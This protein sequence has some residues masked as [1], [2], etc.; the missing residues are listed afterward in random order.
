MNRVLLLTAG[1]CFALFAN[2]QTDTTTK[3]DGWYPGGDTLRVGNILIIRNGPQERATDPYVR[4]R[5]R[6]HD[7]NSYRPPN[8]TTSWGI[9]D[10]G[11]TNYN[12]KTVYT[13][14]SAQQFA[15]GASKDWFKLND[16]KSVDVN[17]WIAVQRLNLIKHVVNLKYGLGIELNNYRYEDNIRFLT[18]PTKVIMDTI[19]YTKNKLAEDF[20][21][22]P[23]MLNF[24]FT[25]HRRH[26][27]G[28]SAGASFG[29]RY[30]SREKF[31]SHEDGKQFTYNDF[32]LYSW[33]I[34]YIGEVQ[35]G[36]WISL[37]GSYATK[38]IFNRGLDQIPYTFGLRFGNW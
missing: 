19:N 20:V 17:I 9:L 3:R 32:D 7:R 22:V 12:D 25:P 23:V 14:A 2:A 11:F 36:T 29:Y 10:L 37:Y 31:K 35:L 33:K 5:S 4:I 16:G 27:F 13:S 6:H 21:T 24:N 30:S 28:F 8:I 38:T 1:L 18:N 15:P 34:S 26:P